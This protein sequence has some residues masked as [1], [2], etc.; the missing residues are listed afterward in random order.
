MIGTGS[1]GDVFR[2]NYIYQTGGH[3]IFNPTWVHQ[4]KVHGDAIYFTTNYDFGEIYRMTSPSSASVWQ[5]FNDAS[6]VYDISWWNDT[7]F[8]SLDSPGLLKRSSD[9]GTSWQEPFKPEGA[10][11][12]YSVFPTRSDELLIGTSP[13]GDVFRSNYIYQTGGHYIFNPTWVYQARVHENAVYFTTDYDFGETY[14]MTSPSSA[15]VWQTFNDAS[16]VYDLN[17][18]NDTVF[19]ALDSPGLLKRSSDEGTSWQ[20]PFKPEGATAVYSVFPTRSDELLIGTSPYGDVFRSNYIYQ[21]GGKYIF[22][23]IWVNDVAYYQDN[24]YI[25]TNMDNGE[26]WKSENSGQDWTNLT[27]NSQPWNRAYTLLAFGNT[28][29]AGTDYNGDVYKSN[30][31]GQN[32]SPTGDLAN[33]TDVYSLYPSQVVQPNRIFAGTGPYGDVFLSDSSAFIGNFTQVDS[34]GWNL[35]GLPLEVADAHYL[36]LYPNAVQNTLFGW[37]GTYQLEDSLIVG[38]GYWL[39][40]PAKDTVT[41]NGLQVNSVQLNLMEG[42]NLISGLSCPMSLTDIDDPS[43]IIIPGTLFGF[44]GVYYSTDTLMPGK[45]YWIRTGAAGMISMSCEI[46]F[47]PIL[48]KQNFSPFNLEESPALQITDATGAAQTLYWSAEELSDEQML[49]YS[50]PPLPPAGAFDAR[51]AGDSRAC[52]GEEATVFVQSTSFPMTLC[53]SAGAGEKTMYEIEEMIGDK[54]VGQHRVLSGM[55]LS[56]TNPTVNCLHIRKIATMPEEFRIFQNYPN[57]FNPA[58]T[59]KFALPEKTRVEVV[60]YNS[61]GQRI[62]TI[63]KAEKEPGFYQLSW[64]GTNDRGQSVAT[65]VYLYSIKAGKY[66]AVRKMLLLR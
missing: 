49:S 65:G 55:Q 48:A 12:V 21:M 7:V 39:R 9:D 44:N 29:Y 28:I 53:F 59:F 22:G 38:A 58:T 24:M 3:Y 40:F 16:E 25:A 20:E 41:I 10:T 23:P 6:E 37:D 60:I 2:S 31:G 57:P 43:G 66:H 27:Q 52:F 64:D 35:T 13:Y 30:D 47:T 18:W 62:K 14:Q 4:A 19:V 26:I 50:L 45:G 51:F 36:T 17:W 42:W 63:A 8:V 34:A 15:S 46:G 33:A 1:Y 54:I 56:V 61:L 5:T 11:A 32:W